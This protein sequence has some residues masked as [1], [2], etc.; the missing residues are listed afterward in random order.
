M[1]AT[2]KIA[3]ISAVKHGFTF[4][5]DSFFKSYRAGKAAIN[6]LVSSGYLEAKTSEFGTEYLPTE[7]ARD[8][9]KYGIEA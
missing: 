2:Q 5:N 9:V 4:T 8:F 7:Q 6:A 3:V 1:N